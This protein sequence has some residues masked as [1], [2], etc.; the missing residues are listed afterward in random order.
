MKVW[1][2]KLLRS[3][4]EEIDLYEWRESELDQTSWDVGR[5]KTPKQTA[6]HEP[7]V[8]LATQARNSYLTARVCAD[9]PKQN[10]L[11][12][13]KFISFSFIPRNKKRLLFVEFSSFRYVKPFARRRLKFKLNLYFKETARVIDFC[14]RAIEQV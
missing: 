12:F 6:L 13:R 10:S 11:I 1:A 9:Y 7:L 5:P 3:I 4:H 8:R 14:A 2:R